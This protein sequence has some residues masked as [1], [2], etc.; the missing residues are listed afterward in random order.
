MGGSLGPEAPHV[1]TS[2]ATRGLLI[3][4]HRSMYPNLRVL[5]GDS[6]E[7]SLGVRHP[8]HC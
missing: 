7:I 8:E 5:L 6:W 2:L 4:P 1:P 3:G